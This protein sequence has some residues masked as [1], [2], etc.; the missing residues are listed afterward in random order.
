MRR[1]GTG[2]FA[3]ALLTP[4]SL[5]AQKPSNSMQTR[6]AEV[7]LKNARSTSN[8]ED[9]KEAYNKALDVLMD[10]AR[11]DADNPKLWLL[12][13]EAYA[14]LGDV[15]G[16]DSAFDKAE[17]LYPDYE[18]EIEPQRFRIW[19]SHYNAGVGDIQ[20]NNYDKAIQE[21]ETANSIYQ[22][23]ADA[24]LSLGSLY[25][26]KGDTE[27]AEKAY[28]G[29]LAVLRG[30]G[31]KK[32]S[33][34]DAKRWREDEDVASTHL[35][36]ILAASGRNDEAAQIYRDLIQRQPDNIQA[37][38]N[39]AV[40]LSRAGKTDEASQIYQQLL[41]RKDLGENV[42]SNIGVGMFRAEQYEPAATAFRRILEKNPY[43]NDALYNLGQALFA[44]GGKLQREKDDATGADAQ[45]LADQM[46]SLYRELGD[47]ATRA[48]ALDPNNRNVM[49]MLAQS[50]RSREGL[51]ASAADSTS[52]KEK[53]LA[54][55]EAADSLTVEVGSIQLAAADQSVRVVGS[56]TNVKLTAGTPIKLQFTL[57]D[58]TGATIASQE[59]SL[60]A[61]DQQKSVPFSFE[62]TTDTPVAGWKYEVT[63]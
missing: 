35:A 15:A 62:V 13:G 29:A 59:V 57:L 48:L 39:L 37:R 60:T 54:T 23:R 47:V 63:T 16:A 14:G 45:H 31:S 34:A 56:V 9:Q 58:N 4:A 25:G 22:G 44:Q 43:S 20:K 8:P 42:L 61:P 7:Y 19:A 24:L 40:V 41:Q 49:M 18:E 27:S 10:G 46:A 55:L 11:H 28:R 38:S 1:L 53:V 6:S 32:L 51:A 30:P 21:F 26:R 12:A 17:K 2:I 33:A 50:Q 36:D 3:L 5:M 52:W